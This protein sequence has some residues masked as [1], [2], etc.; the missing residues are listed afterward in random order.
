MASIVIADRETIV[1]N[2]ASEAA[3][4]RGKALEDLT[5]AV[6]ESIPGVSISKTRI[7][8]DAQSQE[9]DIVAWNDK[10]REG[11]HFLSEILFFEAKNWSRPVGSAEVAWFY[12]KLRHGNARHGFLVIASE[13]TGDPHDATSAHRILYSAQYDG[14]YLIPVSVDELL[15]QDDTGQFIELIKDKLMN[16]SAQVSPIT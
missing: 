1:G 16:M 2:L 6:F 3:A 5:S 9:L 12:W 4:T 7:K 15:A 11:F 8:D 14:Y 13:L 10:Y